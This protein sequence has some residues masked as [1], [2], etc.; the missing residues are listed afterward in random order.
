[1]NTA[2][3]RY[4]KKNKEGYRFMN[5]I[6]ISDFQMRSSISGT[7]RIRGIQ[8][9]KA[10]NGNT[11]M[12]AVLSDATGSI[13]MICWEFDGAPIPQAVELI[14]V[15]G[16]VGSYNG[17]PQ[18][19]AE[20]YSFPDQQKYRQF[21]LSS[22][23]PSAPIDIEEY[24]ARLHRLL[25]S[26]ADQSL[27]YTCFYLFDNNWEDFLTIPAAQFS[28][29][30]FLHGLLMHTV[31]IAELADAAA[32]RRPGVNRDLLIA[33]A[34]LHD[35]GK[36]R[37]FERSPFTGLVTGC[38][39]N[40]SLNGHAAIGFQMIGEAAAAVGADPHMANL[41]QHM[42][43]THHGD[44]TNKI[45]DLPQS[46][47][48]EL[49]RKLDALDSACECFL[50]CRRTMAFDGTNSPAFAMAPEQPYQY[51]DSGDFDDPS[52]WSEVLP[53]DGFDPAGQDTDD[54]YCNNGFIQDYTQEDVYPG[55]HAPVQGACWCEIGNM[56]GYDA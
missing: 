50:E 15:I 46:V 36:I 14:N 51:C 32:Q 1:M 25:E 30:T 26:I 31:D 42:V 3:R 47:E 34:L 49:L 55:E 39:E 37:A 22:L 20:C 5:H 19:L 44:L 2:Q 28:H 7:Y 45:S 21:D 40:G 54:E 29:H 38:T 53:A 43:L 16:T 18:F 8:I 52:D 33:G 35:I 9:R 24:K 12:K 10:R 23:V 4:D 48:E 6:N 13:D 27:L 56:N 11:Y 17:R 41:L